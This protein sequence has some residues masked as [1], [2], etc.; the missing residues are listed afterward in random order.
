MEELEEFKYEFDLRYSQLSHYY[1]GSLYLFIGYVF[2]HQLLR[3]NIFYLTNDELI[4]EFKSSLEEDEIISHQDNKFIFKLNNINDDIIGYIKMMLKYL[5]I[6]YKDFNI[7]YINN[8]INFIRIL[9]ED[10]N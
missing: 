2:L 6:L 9:D 1:N 10:F 4:N 8:E 7:D 5:L 3:N